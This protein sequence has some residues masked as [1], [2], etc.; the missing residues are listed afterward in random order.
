M[1][2]HL[3][4]YEGKGHLVITL[5]LVIAIVLFVAADAFNFNRRYI[6]SISLML[7]SVILWVLDG[8]PD[9][10]NYDPGVRAPRRK[11]ALMWIPVKYWAIILGIGACISLAYAQEGQ[12]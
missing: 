6:G 8:G 9:M 3:I 12:A 10:L 1:L 11:N 5:P 7:S 2:A 4:H